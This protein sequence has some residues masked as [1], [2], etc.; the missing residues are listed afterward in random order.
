[1][2]HPAPLITLLTDFG[3]VDPFVAVMKGVILSIGPELRV[4]D[5]S[6]EIPKFDLRAGA[7][8]LSVAA[9][10]F[11]D[12]TIH[13]AV[14][15]PGVGTPRRRII[16][17]AE[18]SAPGGSRKAT[19]IGPDNGLFTGV[20]DQAARVTAY[21]IAELEKLPRYPAAR[22]FDG[23]N[24]FA[25][26]AALLAIGATPESGFG[27]EIPVELLE[28]LP[29]SAAFPTPDGIRGEI[30]SFDSY[31][32]AATNIAAP[33]LE[34][35]SLRLRLVNRGLVLAVSSCFSEIP[36]SSLGAIINSDG[37]IELAV[38]RGDA[39]QQYALADHEAIE[40][41]IR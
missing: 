32:N 25:P 28:R 34:I 29:S 15:D 11:P 12:R 6:H 39:K 40:L 3:T 23:R 1:M 36:P 33:N 14:V 30:V 2:N 10:Y 22:T 16:L 24:V 26:A 5:L 18:Y 19:F 17:R 13:V 41:L 38:N 4:I 9:P 31:G 37:F 27:P 21:E 20:I 7:R 8:V 35:S